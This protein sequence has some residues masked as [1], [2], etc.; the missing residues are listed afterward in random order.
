VKFLAIFLSVIMLAMAFDICQD[1]DSC[2]DSDETELRKT[3]EQSPEDGEPCSPFC[4]CLRCPFSILLPVMSSEFSKGN[5]TERKYAST[6]ESLTV[7][8]QKAVWQPP[9]VA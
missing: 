5:P 6:S 8:V 2:A 1:T 9:K 3:T 7:I 4:H